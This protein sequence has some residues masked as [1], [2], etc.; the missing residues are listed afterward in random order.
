M[1]DKKVKPLEGRSSK[2]GVCPHLRG[3]NVRK[4][5]DK[6]RPVREGLNILDEGHWDNVGTDKL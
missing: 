5:N 1:K 4:E 3:M 6:G 2:H